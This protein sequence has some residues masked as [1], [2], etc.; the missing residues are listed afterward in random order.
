MSSNRNRGLIVLELTIAQTRL[1]ECEQKNFSLKM[2]KDR[3]SQHN[4]LIR[5]VTN[6]RDMLASVTSSSK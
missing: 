4:A 5:R 2:T 6:A 3:I 1:R